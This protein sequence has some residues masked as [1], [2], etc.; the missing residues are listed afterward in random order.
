MEDFLAAAVAA[1]Q[2][3]AQVLVEKDIT[4]AAEANAPRNGTRRA[5]SGK[6][7]HGSLHSAV[8]EERWREQCGRFS[9]PMP[10][11]RQAAICGGGK[12]FVTAFESV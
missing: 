8:S 5:Y 3:A 10:K 9:T 4:E 12:H 6:P 7:C 11:L 2:S 1:A